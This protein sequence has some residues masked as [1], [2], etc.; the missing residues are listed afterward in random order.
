ML[1]GPT[2]GGEKIGFEPP[3]VPLEAVCATCPR[4]SS[5]ILF[6][7]QSQLQRKLAEASLRIRVT[8][9]WSL[10]FQ[11]RMV[12]VPHTEDSDAMLC[13]LRVAS[14]RSLASSVHALV[15]CGSSVEPHTGKK[16]FAFLRLYHLPFLSAGLVRL[17]P[18]TSKQKPTAKQ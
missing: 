18:V 14:L 13:E 8:V 17:N 7:L 11:G 10:G 15:G 12:G 6:Q 1:Y 2:L 3:S 9:A 16:D 4:G 5:R